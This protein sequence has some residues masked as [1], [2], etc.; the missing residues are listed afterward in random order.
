MESLLTGL[1]TSV[2]V[3]TEPMCEAPFLC[4][5]AQ[6]RST[7]VADTYSGSTNAYDGWIVH[8]RTHTEADHAPR[9][10]E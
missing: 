6:T 5:R 8:T 1:Y 10:S 9:D 4:A 2:M 3:I 7:V